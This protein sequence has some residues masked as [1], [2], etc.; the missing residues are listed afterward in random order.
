MAVKGTN[1][2]HDHL[3]TLDT[4]VKSVSKGNS[5]I[6]KEEEKRLILLY[7]NGTDKEKKDSLEILVSYNVT[8]FAD[9]AISVI[10][11]IRGGDRIDPLD[12]MQLAVITYMKKLDT[13]DADKN[14]K[15]I[16]YYYRE[17]RTQMQRFV[18][19]NAFQI[20]QGSVFLQHLAYTISKLRN[21]WLAE[22]ETEPTLEIISRETG[23]SLSTIKS[24]LKATNL[25][26]MSMSDAPVLTKLS[27]PGF[28]KS[29]VLDI[30]ENIINSKDLTLLEKNLVY[31]Y[32][33]R[34][35]NLPPELIEKLGL[36]DKFR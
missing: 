18:M 29:P 3:L 28:S 13:W 22:Y 21:S 23:V 31:S 35:D 34:K 4:Y 25:Q 8:V 6:D 36:Y 33:D 10:N 12:L 19:A 2:S 32:L 24:C 26:I 7:R 11:T 16:T 17:A 14:S 9:I 30:I 1:I 20:K 15:M 27:E 5:H